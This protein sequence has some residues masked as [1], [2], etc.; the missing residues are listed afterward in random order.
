MLNK[1]KA[2]GHKTVAAAAAEE[3]RRR[4]LSGELSEGA[5][6]R[7]EAFATEFGV[8]RIP[9]RE[10]LLQLEAEGLVR[11]LPHRGA[12]VSALSESEISEL[13]ELRALLEPRLLKLSVKHLSDHD[14]DTLDH[15]RRQYSEELKAG[16]PARWGELNTQLHLLLL[17]RASQPQTMQI[18]FTLLQ[19]TDRYTRL[20]L[21]LTRENSSRAEEE[22]AELIRLCRAQEAAKAAA[23][24]EGH[25]KHAGKSLATFVKAQRTAPQQSL[26][27]SAG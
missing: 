21:A 4:I 1:Q 25:I 2:L 24:L 8:S 17:S 26:T 11:S 15:I 16:N 13:F 10:A 22:H 19:Q 20:Q 23:L 27:F 6:L 3:I 9:I 18:V 5:P 12:V 7:Q 14:F